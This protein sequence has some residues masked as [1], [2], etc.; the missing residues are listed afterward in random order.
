MRPP[1]KDFERVPVG[2]EVRGIIEEV[3][4]DTRSFKAYKEGDEDTTGP[5]VRF[6]FKL[7]GCSFPHYSRWMKFNV[8]EKANLYKKYLVELVENA[9]PNMDMDLDELNSMRVITTWADNGDFQNLE[10][11]A[12][13][14]AKITADIQEGQQELPF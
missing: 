2:I 9:V 4:Y 13:E 11:I 12:A 14:D 7:D 10:T 8:G 6:K 5:A 3:Q 1:K